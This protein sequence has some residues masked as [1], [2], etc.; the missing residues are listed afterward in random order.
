MAAVPR[1]RGGVL[2]HLT[3]LFDDLFNFCK[4]GR[5]MRQGRR[6]MYR[7]FFFSQCRYCLRMLQ[8]TTHSLVTGAAVNPELLIQVRAMRSRRVTTPEARMAATKATI[9]SDYGPN[10][11]GAKL[12]TAGMHRRH[13][14][15]P[16]REG[17]LRPSPDVFL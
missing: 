3:R 13:P 1:V 4:S 9:R 12:Y 14:E 16:R 5:T 6:A 8:S 7:R 10:P 17:S 2:A 11:N 15:R